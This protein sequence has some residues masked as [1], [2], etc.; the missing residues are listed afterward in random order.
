MPLYPFERAEKLHR[1]DSKSHAPWNFWQAASVFWSVYKTAFS[2]DIEKERI[3]EAQ[4]LGWSLDERSV[5]GSVFHA[6]RAGQ[7]EKHW[8]FLHGT[9]AHAGK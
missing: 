4:K 2:L 5:Q 3:K 7:G 6:I 9:P 1:E 8:V